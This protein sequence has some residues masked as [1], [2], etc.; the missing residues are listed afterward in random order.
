MTAAAQADPASRQRRW[1]WLRPL[2][3]RGLINA[4]TLMLVLLVPP[5]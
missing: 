4:I 5:Q 3:V 2:L 1:P